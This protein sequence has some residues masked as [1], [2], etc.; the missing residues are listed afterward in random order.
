MEQPKSLYQSSERVITQQDREKH[1]SQFE[2]YLKEQKAQ[3]EINMILDN[4]EF[5]NYF[6]IRDDEGSPAT[7]TQCSRLS[8]RSGDN[9]NEMISSLV[10][11]TIGMRK[12]LPL[13]T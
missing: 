13:R 9:R 5:R 2:D 11:R 7:K 12:S 4:Y 6:T 3:P 8:N 10:N 1:R